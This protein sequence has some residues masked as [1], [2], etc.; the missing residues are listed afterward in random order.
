MVG[1]PKLNSQVCIRIYIS[2]PSSLVSYFIMCASSF[3]SKT[4]TILLQLPSCL[5]VTPCNHSLGAIA[6][7]KFQVNHWEVGPRNAWVHHLYM[8]LPE[9]KMAKA[10]VP[11][12]SEIN[13]TGLGMIGNCM[14]LQHGRLQPI[15][16]WDSVN[17]NIT[18]T[19]A[20]QA[21]SQEMM[22]HIWISA[23]YLGHNAASWRCDWLQLCTIISHLVALFIFCFLLCI[24]KQFY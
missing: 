3:L 8:R 7:W 6:T 23:V 14:Q 9:G 15:K 19:K 4:Q 22:C 10:S 1:F 12:C 18:T 17:L 13:M 11:M 16:L 5:C 21:V 20:T 2:F 24:F